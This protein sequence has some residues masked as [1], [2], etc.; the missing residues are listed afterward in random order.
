MVKAGDIGKASKDFLKKDFF[1][2]N[3]VKV[4]QAG[5]CASKNT[6]TF[7]LGDAVKAD[8]KIEMKSCPLT[9]VPAKVTLGSTTATDVEWTFKQGAASNKLTASTNLASILDVNNLKLKNEFDF[10]K[11]V[12]GINTHLN[13]NTTT[14]GTNFLQPIN[15][16]FGLEKSGYQFGVTGTVNDITAPAVSKNVFTVGWAGCSNFN[17]CASTT[18]GSDWVLNGLLKKD[19]RTY[20]VD[21]DCNNW[22]ANLATNIPNGKLKVCCS[23]VL[24]SYQ[25]FPVSESVSARFGGQMDLKSGQ[26][27][28]MGIGIDFNL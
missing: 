14:K 22:G 6:T 7:K 25:K 27:S 18:T 10:A 12:S 2:H 9:K 17:V 20:A 16:G 11:D 3:E 1:S 24:T 21:L 4:T 8:H 23:G 5:C 28:G 26:V 13:M 19:G 15:F